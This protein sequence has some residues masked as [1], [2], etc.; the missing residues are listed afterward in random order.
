MGFFSSKAKCAHKDIV[1]DSFLSAEFFND[2][3]V[4]K[5]SRIAAE[6]LEKLPTEHR[7]R[8]QA[9]RPWRSFFD[10][11]HFSVP[12][13]VEAT[14]RFGINLHYF[15]S[16]YIAVSLAIAIYQ[17]LI[18][19]LLLFAMLGCGAFAAYYNTLAKNGQRVVFSG[20]VIPDNQVYGFLTGTAVFLFWI[21]GG[22]STV[23]WTF[24][25][26]LAAITGHSTFRDVTDTE[27]LMK[28]MKGYSG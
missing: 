7:K 16:N 20:N 5:I 13:M 1:L 22:T 17:I 3:S 6:F 27:I 25:L 26:C 8:I 18:H 9:I 12:S 24:S 28:E 23:L 11:D 2:M 4:E 14:R 21:T 15:S 10:G 19:P